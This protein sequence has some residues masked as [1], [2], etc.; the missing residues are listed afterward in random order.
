MKTLRMIGLMLICLA[1]GVS[2]EDRRPFTLGIDP[3]VVK[4]PTSPAT[5][6]S[7]RT[8]WWMF[9]AAW[10]GPCQT[11]RRD[12]EG[13]LKQSGWEVDESPEAHVRIIDADREPQCAQAHAIR[14][15]PTFLLMRDGQEQQRFETYPGR[16]ELVRLFQETANA[17]EPAAGAISVGTITGQCENVARVIDAV[18]PLLSEGGTLTLTW[19]RAGTTPALLPVG[20]RFSICIEKTLAMTYSLKDD[21]LTC[22][23]SQPY[24]RGRFSWG[25]PVEQSVSAISLSVSEVVFEL[26]R[27]PDV[28]LRVEP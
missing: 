12:F 23:F 5:N 21:V 13:W 25:L 8:Q 3:P 20:E 14:T 27:A 19:D 4:T 17:T 10:C 28:R 18:S 15:F 22:R 1:G 7:Q 9:T 11:A 6:H 24:P 16:W 26:P 2:A